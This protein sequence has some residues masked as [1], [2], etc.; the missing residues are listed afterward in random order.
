MN[1]IKKRDV[2]SV[3]AGD[4][5][6]VNSGYRSETLTRVTATTKTQIVIG[7][8]RYNR[9]DGYIRGGSGYCRSYLTI[10]SP[11]DLAKFER[12]YYWNRIKDADPTLHQELPTA[13]LAAFAIEVLGYNPPQ[14]LSD[15]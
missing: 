9:K 8:C 12:E 5:V 4:L 1:L 7:N 2:N 13:A 14:W 10:P 6:V 11:E 3:E 15:M